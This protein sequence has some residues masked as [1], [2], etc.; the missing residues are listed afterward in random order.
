MTNPRKVT[1]GVIIDLIAKGTDL[2][3]FEKFNKIDE[4]L[5]IDV[6]HYDEFKIEYA[7]LIKENQLL[8]KRLELLEQIIIQNRCIEK[9][10]ESIKL[11]IVRD[12]IYARA[13]F[14]RQ[15]NEVDDIRIIVGKTDEYGDNVEVLSNDDAFMS[16]AYNKLYDAMEREIKKSEDILQHMNT[17]Q[18]S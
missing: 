3:P 8:F 1:H 10:E 6:T 4:V 11:L 2:T 12:Y 17:Y 18:E 16:I 14:Y 5:G 15:D 13:L 9:I 7:N